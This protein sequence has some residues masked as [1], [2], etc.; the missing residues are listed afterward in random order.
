MSSTEIIVRAVDQ[1][2]GIAISMAIKNG[3]GH[4]GFDNVSNS[5]VG[6][7][8]QGDPELIEMLANINP[9]LQSSPIDITYEHIHPRGAVDTGPEDTGFA[10]P[11]PEELEVDTDD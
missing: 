3:L 2:E 1:E 10:E 8:D 9:E 11:D 4:F 5:V 6:A 7:T